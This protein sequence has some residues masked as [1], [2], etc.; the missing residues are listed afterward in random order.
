MAE[1]NQFQL[2]RE[3]R[4]LPFFLTQALGAFNDNVFKNALVIL[5]AFLTTQLSVADVNFYTNLAA[6]LFILPFLLFSATSGQLSDKYDKAR[7]AQIVKLLEIA[8]M[9]A[10][11]SHPPP[12]VARGCVGAR[13]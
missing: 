7:L 4:F 11:L 13:G 2:L 12:E 9:N 1:G 10:G 5:V 6:A 3:R 8:I